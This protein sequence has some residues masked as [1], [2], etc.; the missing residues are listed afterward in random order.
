MPDSSEPVSA[1]TRLETPQPEVACHPAAIVRLSEL[2]RWIADLPNANPLRM[3]DA[4]GQQ[5]GLLVRYPQTPGRFADL[6]RAFQPTILSLHEDLWQQLTQVNDL[7][8]KAA[9]LEAHQR[10]PCLEMAYAYMRLV[11]EAM[12][13]AQSPHPQHLYLAS[14]LLGRLLLIDLL[15][16]RPL[17]QELWR[18]ILRLYAIAEFYSLTGVMVETRMRTGRE[19]R[20]VHGLFFRLLVLL[21]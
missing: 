15:Y 12:D 19:P 16:Y 18:H 13:K 5:L 1:L 10:T 11:N 8:Q 14:L 4:V 2:Q 6:I 3:A 20:N 17:R 21:L 9:P 7:S